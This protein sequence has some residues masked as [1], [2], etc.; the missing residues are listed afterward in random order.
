MP[1]P[2]ATITIRRKRRKI[3]A[4]LSNADHARDTVPIC[5]NIL[6]SPEIQKAQSALMECQ[7][8]LNAVVKDPLPEALR[9]A[10]EAAKSRKVTLNELDNSKGILHVKDDNQGQQTRPSERHMKDVNTIS[11]IKMRGSA[12]AFGK[13]QNR[14]IMDRNP[15]AQKIEVGMKL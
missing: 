5:R 13:K 7:A 4:F 14:S 9:I 2:S 12:Q 15:T 8:S 10:E 1:D 11:P 3:G 6:D